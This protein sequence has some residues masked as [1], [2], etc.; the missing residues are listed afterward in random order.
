MLDINL[1]A[2]RRAQRQRTLALIRLAFYGLLGLGILVVLLYVWM[3]IQISLANGRI[4]EA[5]AKLNAPD[6]QNKL[7]RV[8]Y[9]ES[10]IAELEPKA[11]VLQKVHDSE[12]SWI[13]IMRHVGASVPANVWVTQVASRN[14]DR[15]QQINL[16]GSAVS[17]RLIGAYML[18]LQE[19]DWFG[20]IQLIQADTSNN[21][22]TEK[23]DFEI[24]LP[25]KEGIGLD[26]LKPETEVT[27]SSSP[28]SGSA[29]REGEN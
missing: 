11:V 1:I 13:D 24:I 19:S 6:V 15:G 29:P 16:Q 10:Q 12:S 5:D 23:V 14:V 17:Q 21:K 3:S 8:H 27:E 9:L 18:A 2:S 4:I 26:L 7:D 20:T 22:G 25:L 28:T